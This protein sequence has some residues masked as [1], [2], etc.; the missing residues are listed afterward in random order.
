[1]ARD[2]AAAFGNWFTRVTPRGAA[3]RLAPLL[4]LIALAC[5]AAPRLIA[6]AANASAQRLAGEAASASARR[7]CGS[8]PRCACFIKARGAARFV[9]GIAQR[10]TC[11]PQT[12]Q[13]RLHLARCLY[14]VSAAAQK[15]QRMRG[16]VRALLH[17]HGR[18]VARH[19][20]AG[21]DSRD[22][23]TTKMTITRKSML[24]VY[25]V[26]AGAYTLARRA[27]VQHEH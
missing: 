17:W 23:Q 12:A 2:A 13:L 3:L 20:A 16:A 10:G 25:A 21:G 9:T 18:E 5:A 19:L 27:C 4:S 8:M 6:P 26:T 7:A 15:Q 24:G 22:E 14:H 11:A 1:M